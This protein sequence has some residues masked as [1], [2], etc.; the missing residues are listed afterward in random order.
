MPTP[1]DS[2]SIPNR[3]TLHFT[4]I[5]QV[6]AAAD[7]AGKLTQ[8]GNWT[9]GQNLGHLASW[10]DYSF[11]GPP[12]TVPTPIRM[13]I[14]P[15]RR[16]FLYKRMAPGRKLPKSKTGTFGTDPLS[17]DEGLSRFRTNFT[18][19]S[20]ECPKI[21]NVL[22]G[23]LTHD[24]WINLHLRHAELHLSFLLAEN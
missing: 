19:I 8:L 17:T 13:L 3:R 4:T 11:N 16:R 14:R 12:M 7:R 22:F 10:V 6:I 23:P 24:E 9:F 18:R 15:F 1:V 2:K 5:P 21:P 20:T